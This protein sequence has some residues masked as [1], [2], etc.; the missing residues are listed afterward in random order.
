ARAFSEDAA[1]EEVLAELDRLAGETGRH[2]DLADLLDSNAQRASDPEVAV[3]LL[4]R[5]AQLA[6]Q[7]LGDDAR[8][9][10]AMARAVEHGGDRDELLVE[11]DRLYVKTSSWNDLGPVLER[12]VELVFEPAAQI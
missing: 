8:A 12:R 4:E 10:S 11:L 5:V 9:A 1:D 6:E 2:R 3:R 7:N